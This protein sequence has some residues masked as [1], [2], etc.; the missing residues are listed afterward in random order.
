MPNETFTTSFHADYADGYYYISA[1]N[2]EE[3]NMAY[4][5]NQKEWLKL[6]PEIKI[7]AKIMVVCSW[8]SFSNEE[9]LAI[10]WK[11]NY[12]TMMDNLINHTCTINNIS[13][14][15]G[16]QLY[17]DEVSDPQG[18]WY[19]FCC[20]DER[21]K[22]SLILSDGVEQKID[23]LDIAYKLISKEIM[24]LEKKDKI[25]IVIGDRK[26]DALNVY[27]PYLLNKPV[28]FMKKMI[29]FKKGE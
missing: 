3:E 25:W 27:N 28:D 29:I 8:N 2:D 18:Y 22:I 24:K 6:H 23:S 1:N 10:G 15:S 14:R 26:I 11:L 20:L 13:A 16:I 5:L 12:P 9:Q 7:G 4:G 21:G 17:C 19:P